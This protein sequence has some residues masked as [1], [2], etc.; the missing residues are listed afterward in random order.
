MNIAIIYDN[1]KD[2]GK[3]EEL[4]ERALEGKEAQLGKDNEST[5]NCARNLKTCLE[6]SGNN[7][8]LAQLL[9]VYPKLKTN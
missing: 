7:K 6:A 8:R 4:Y 2:Y 5:I 3:A 1:L 9:A